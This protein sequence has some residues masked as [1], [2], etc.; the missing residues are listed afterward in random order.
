M[1]LACLLWV[2]T[3]NDVGAVFLRYLGVESGLFT[4]ET[5]ENDLSVLG[6]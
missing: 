3:T 1:S 2:G 6:Q 5:L 4:G